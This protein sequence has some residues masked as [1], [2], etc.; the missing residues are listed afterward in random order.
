MP[1]VTKIKVSDFI[2]A[3]KKYVQDKVAQANV[4]SN[5]YLTKTEAKKLP[6]DLRDNFENFR[7]AQG[8]DRVSVANFQKSFA[9]YVAA[10]AHSAD[11]NHDGVL[12]AADAKKLPK[13][14][15]DNFWNYVHAS[16]SA[17]AG[18]TF[19]ATAIAGLKKWVTDNWDG[20]DDLGGTELSQSSLKGDALKD[21]KE[22]KRQWGEDYPPEAEIVEM[23]GRNVILIRENN[24]GGMSLG[25]YAMSGK[26]LAEGG[27]SESGTFSWH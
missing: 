5:N 12:T 3:S 24:D 14:L 2:A 16:D 6:A 22:M 25:L 17:G 4:D 23:N 20:L 9:N 27:C 1:T 15:Q 10:Q 8:G 21:F 11:R 26:R 19:S 13:D 18:D 7:G